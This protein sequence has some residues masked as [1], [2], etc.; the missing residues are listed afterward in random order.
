MA[1]TVYCAFCGATMTLVEASRHFC[2]ARNRFIVSVYDCV[3]RLVYIDEEGR[4]R[5]VEP[6]PPESLL[7]GAIERVGGAIN[8]SGYYPLSD[9]LKEW[10]SNTDVSFGGDA[11]CG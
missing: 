2:D 9:E 4:F 6:Q 10:L 7:N 5:Q 11:E 3:A 8:L 1:T